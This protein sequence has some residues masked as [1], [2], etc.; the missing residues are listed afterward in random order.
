[1][2]WIAAFAFC[3]WTVQRSD[4]PL[5]DIL[6]YAA[7]F[8]AGVTVPGVLLLRGCTT[9]R[10][11][12]AEDVGV[13]TAVGLAYEL[14][15]WAIWTG[16]GLPWM[17]VVWALAVPAVFLLV[18]GLRRFWR[19]ADGPRLPVWWSAALALV[20][21]AAIAFWY[22]ASVHVTTTPPNGRSYYPDLL[23]HL[24]LVQEAGRHVPPQIPQVAGET[25]KYHWFADAHLASAEHITGLDPR[26]IV[27]RLWFA[28]LLAAT[29][30]CVAALARQVSG[31]CWTGPVA[32][33]VAVVVTRVGLWDHSAVVA[34]MPAYFLSPSQTYGSLLCVAVAVLMLLVLFGRE[35]RRAWIPVVML[36][37]ASAGAKPTTIPLLL[38]GTGLAALF[39]LIRNRRLHMASLLTGVGLVLLVLLAAMSV[40]GSTAGTAVRLLGALRVLPGYATVTGDRSYPAPD[41]GLVI[42]GLQ[43][44]DG[45]VIQWT[46]VTLLSLL[47]AVA[48]CVAPVLVV[49]VR[50]TRTDPVYWWLLGALTAG[51]LGFLLVDHPGAAEYYFLGSAVPFGAVLTTSLAAAGMD[52]RSPRTRRTVLIG[53]LA[54]AIFVVVVIRVFG[55]VGSRPAANEGDAI[56][57]AVARP[58]IWFGVAV[59][60]AVVGWLV[61]RRV[62]PTVR[63]LG[64]TVVATTVLGLALAGRT[65]YEWG[66]ALAMD[67]PPGPELARPP[68]SAAENEAADW[69]GHNVPADDVVATNTL[70]LLPRLPDKCDARGYIVSGIGGRRAYIEGWAYTAQ[71]MKNQQPG[72]RYTDLP[73]PWPDRVQL[74]YRAIARPSEATMDELRYAGVRWLFVDH[75][76]GEPDTEGLRR[77]ADQRFDNGGV[78]IYELQ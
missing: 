61:L 47:I 4:A 3:V 44:A 71:S 41:A 24:A 31:Y 21:S 15:G 73:S 35:P 26:L 34:V 76:F 78:Q 23:W 32:A 65:P 30:L 25:M 19:L 29:V 18:P 14:A 45:R 63:G 64:I 20:V 5:L 10:R 53:S 43:H 28:P 6:R 68:F 22:A 58:V 8:G 56:T 33:A 36:L 74:T 66:D 54:A 37:G 69:V 17:Q 11:T 62:R 1:M 42:P 49:V 72:V 48:T 16:L 9:N 7:Y 57:A 50:R 38:A 59:L 40:T 27:F 75:R 13:G 67:T 55:N 12:L 77:Y 70:C 39:L 52:E 60:L 2:I 46:V 51:W